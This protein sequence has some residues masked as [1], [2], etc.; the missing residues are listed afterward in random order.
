MWHELYS[1]PSI[2]NANFGFKSLKNCPLIVQNYWKY[3]VWY[4]FF[5]N[6]NNLF[7]DTGIA[8]YLCFKSDGCCPIVRKVDQRVWMILLWKFYW[9][10]L[11]ESAFSML[12]LKWEKPQSSIHLNSFN[13]TSYENVGEKTVQLL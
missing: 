4:C 11:K 8:L 10:D 12:K 7:E 2:L 3:N 1:N 13:I 9:F 5:Y 6:F